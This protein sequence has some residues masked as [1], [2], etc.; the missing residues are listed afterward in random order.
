MR[1][2]NSKKALVLRFMSPA[3]SRSAER[4]V[5]SLPRRCSGPFSRRCPFRTCLRVASRCVLSGLLL[6]G[7]L[8][9][10]DITWI[11][12]GGVRIRLP[13]S[14]PDAVAMFRPA[15]AWLDEQ[16]QPSEKVQR[17]ERLPNGIL[18][19]MPSRERV[20][21]LRNWNAHSDSSTWNV[22][23][24]APQLIRGFIPIVRPMHGQYGNARLLSAA[25]RDGNLVQHHP[26]ENLGKTR[27]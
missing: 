15:R 4:G 10:F 26:R 25:D 12:A 22:T 7:G 27:P 2:G 23:G 13:F 19:A 5:V 6:A 9:R 20:L 14:L 11:L 24:A 8:F 1:V 16:R 3:T 18:Q 21:E 17:E